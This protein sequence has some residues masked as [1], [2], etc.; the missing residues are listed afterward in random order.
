MMDGLDEQHFFVEL[1]SARTQTTRPNCKGYIRQ[2]VRD[3]KPKPGFTFSNNGTLDINFANTT[4]ISAIR[5]PDEYTWIFGDD[6]TITTTSLTHPTHTYAACGSYRVTLIARKG[7][8][9]QVFDTLVVIPCLAILDTM[10]CTGATYTS[11]ALS[12]AGA[13]VTWRNTQGEVL[14][15]GT[16]YQ[17]TYTQSDTLVVTASNPSLTPLTMV[18]TVFIAVQ[19]FPESVELIADTMLCIGETARIKV[20]DPNSAMAKWQWAG[21]EPSSPPTVTNPSVSDSLIIP[22]L[23]HDTVIYLIAQTSQGCAVVRSIPIRIT[24][25]IVTASRTKICPQE[26]VVLTG[27]KAASYSWIADPADPTLAATGETV[28]VSPLQSTTY[29]MTGYGTSGCPV[30]RVV[31]IEVIP[32][33]IASIGCTP[34]YVDVDNP[35]LSLSDNS[36]YGKTSHWE[37][38]AGD[39]SNARSVNYRFADVSGDSVLIRLTSYNELGC[40]N[41]TSIYVPIELFAVWL[42]SGFTPDGDGINDRFFFF[43]LNKLADVKF[44]IYN[45]WGGTVYSYTGKV[46]DPSATPDALNTIGWDGTHNGVKAPQGAYVYKLIYSRE[47]NKRVYEK[48]GTINI[49]R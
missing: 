45:R 8:C 46:F 49:I 4:E 24:D 36:S 1:I 2:D 25:P 20:N 29:T 26:E 9:E 32:F 27:S 17:S 6:D 10:I 30:E 13:I 44:E 48:T 14:E 12:D 43:T 39:T 22:N 34:T 16:D 5:N 3:T 18:D 15:I 7:T 21:V 33:P 23:Q 31:R 11:Y 40:S 37:F 19:D 38:P 42:P 47:G 28:T 41:S 35:V